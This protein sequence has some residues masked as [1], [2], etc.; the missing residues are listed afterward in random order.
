M[1]KVILIMLATM[2]SATGV[3]GNEEGE[4]QSPRDEV[5]VF[6]LERVSTTHIPPAVEGEE[7]YRNLI[8]RLLICGVAGSAPAR[9][10]S[11][12]SARAP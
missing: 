12:G 9:D 8:E 2:A 3:L 4:V 10:I 5:E 7:P 11:L 1:K 6:I